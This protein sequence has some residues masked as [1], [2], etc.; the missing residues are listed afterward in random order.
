MSNS[1][2]FDRSSRLPAATL[3]KSPRCRIFNP[4]HLK[5]LARFVR[6]CAPRNQ[7]ISQKCLSRGTCLRTSYVGV[8]GLLGAAA[9][10]VQWDLDGDGTVDVPNTRDWKGL[11]SSSR[12]RH[13]FRDI[14]RGT[15]NTLVM[16]EATGGKVSNIRPDT[17]SGGIHRRRNH[18]SWR[19]PKFDGPAGSHRSTLLPVRLRGVGRNCETGWGRLSRGR[20]SFRESA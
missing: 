11:F 19:R 8:G 14:T 15:S 1:V 5:R 3:L 18:C 6:G 16:G 17:G 12:T 20:L 13:A 9:C 7:K 4:T 10:N 2:C